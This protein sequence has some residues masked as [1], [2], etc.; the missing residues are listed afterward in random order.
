MV[1]GDY[2]GHKIGRMRL[3][4]ILGAIALVSILGFAIYAAFAAITHA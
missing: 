1:L 4:T 3:A 2:L